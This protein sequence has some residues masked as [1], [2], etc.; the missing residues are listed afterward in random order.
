MNWT[1][2]KN[3]NSIITKNDISTNGLG[4]NLEESDGNTISHNQIIRNRAI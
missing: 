4:L 1:I 2:V 3:W